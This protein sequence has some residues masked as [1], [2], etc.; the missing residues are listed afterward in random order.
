M[1]IA[2]LLTMGTVRPIVRWDD[3]ILHRR[4]AS[5][6]DFGPELQALLAD[7]FA[8]NT[9]AH[10]AGLA[11]PQVGVDLAVFVLDCVDEHGTR[12]IGVICNPELELPEG[13][14]RRL[15]TVDEGCLSFPGAYSALAR[16]STATCRGQDQFGDPVT[17][18]AGGIAGRCL[19]HE[20]DHCNG[21]VF[22]DRLSAR[23]RKELRRQHDAGIDRYPDDWPVSRKLD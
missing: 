16:P 14:D 22:G 8:T 5:V 20:T 1:P 13:A 17:I 18:T 7:M 4:M 19:Q 2:E 9:A 12:R 11:A 23:A 15:D 6:T 10:G 21:M 3:P